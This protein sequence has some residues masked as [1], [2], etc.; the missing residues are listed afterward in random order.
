MT[1]TITKQINISPHGI[2]KIIHLSQYDKG[3]RVLSLELYEE[4][5]TFSIPSGSTVTIRGTKPDH[6][7][8]EYSC[9]YSGS[10][11]TVTVQ[12]QMTAVAGN[13]PCEVRITGSDGSILGTANFTLAVKRS[14]LASDVTV[15]KTELPLIEKAG[16][17]VQEIESLLVQTKTSEANAAKSATAASKS[18]SAAAA[19][20]TAAKTSEINAANS[21]KAA[22]TSEK[23][24]MSATPDGYQELASTF[25]AIGLYVDEDGDIC[26]KDD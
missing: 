13:V 12:D 4:S 22:A 25:N 18:A 26:Q 17:N 6:T 16:Q 14:A 23:N 10:V 5:G 20:E 8:F 21:A 15:S 11:V 19:S 1:Q 9:T 3:S 2:P 7:G 24:A